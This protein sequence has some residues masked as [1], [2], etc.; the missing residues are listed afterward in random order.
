MM[1][2]KAVWLRRSGAACA[3][4]AA[5]W[6]LAQGPMPDAAA[7]PDAVAGNH[8]PV[9]VANAAGGVVRV[10]AGER[11]TLVIEALDP[12]LVEGGAFE[13]VWLGAAPDG[14]AP[15]WIAAAEWAS[16]PSAQPRLELT[17]APSFDAVPGQYAI[18]AGATD[19]RGLTALAVFSVMVQ[20]P[21]CGGLE[22][23]EEGACRRC[24]SH[25]VPNA[26]RTGCEPC[27]S[28]TER[29][30]GA[31]SCAT[32]PPGLV[33]EPGRACDCGPARIPVG[34]A[35]EDCPPHMEAAGGACVP[36]PPDTERPAGTEACTDCEPGSTSVGG[37]ACAA[38][39]GA[40]LAPLGRASAK[41][42]PAEADTVAPEIVSADYVGSRVTLTLSE[43]VWAA[44]APATGDF[45]LTVTDGG[46][47][48]T[49]TVTAVEVAA[50]QAE[51]SAEVMLTLS[52]ALGGSASVS[53]AYT[54]NADMAKRPRDAAGNPLGTQTVLA[55]ARRTL[56]VDFGPLDPLAVGE[57][58]GR[59]RATLTLENPPD[60]GKYTGCGL[61]LAA[62]SE[63]DGEDVAFLA[64]DRQLKPGNRW[65]TGRVRLFRV[66]DDGLAEGEE[67][68]VVEGHCGG[69]DAGMV[70][71][72]AELRREPAAL[73]L[74]DDESRT[75]TLSVDPD[76]I[77]EAAEP[78][79]VKVTAT[80]D[81]EATDELLLPL[82]LAGTATASDYRVTGTQ[83]I[84]IEAGES[85]GT[86]VLTV[87]PS[88]DDDAADDTIVLD[89]A[90]SG[91][92]VAGATVTITE[93][94]G[95]VATLAGRR[96]KTLRE[97]V[98]AVK[99]R[100]AIR[101]KPARGAYTGCRLRL[102]SGS[103]A[104]TPADV[105][106][107]NRVKLN[108]QND[109]KDQASLLKVVDDAAT[110]GD[111]ALV[112]EG[113]CTSSKS[114]AEPR[115]T[116]LV[117]RPLR[118]TIR[119]NEAPGPVTLTVS[120]DRIG[121]TLGAQAVTVTATLDRA[122][123]GP[124]AVDLGLGA[125]S[126]M[127]AGTQRIEIA[128]GAESGATTLT[129]TPSDDGNAT[130]DRVAVTG[131]ASGRTVTSTS[132]TI[133]EPTIVGGVD[134]SGLGVDVSVSPA[135]IAEGSSGPHTVSATLTGVQVP[136]VDVALAL[137][138]R[139]TATQGSSHDYTLSGAANW[140]DLTVR[141]NGA[142]LT[143]RAKVTVAALEDAVED[144][145]ET[146]T[147]SVSRV[148]WGTAVVSLNAPA[149]ATLTI[150][151]PSNAPPAPAGLEVEPASGDERHGFDV[152][153]Q[154][155]TA[156]PPV[157]GY[158]VRHRKVADPLPDW[159]DSA[160][161]TGLATTITGLSAGTRYEVRAYARSSAGDGA[162]SGSV[163]AY[164]ADGDCTV[165]APRVA[166]PSG[167][168]SST[169]L[170]VTWEAAACAPATTIAN[171]RVR[172][173]EDP[174]VEAVT[175]AWLEE[176]SNT[177]AATLAGL[178]A[179]TA[180]VVEVRAVAAGGDNGP[181]SP[182][183]KG[184]TALDSRLPPR[185]GAPVVAA[186]ATHG[187]RRLDAT[188]RRVT[189]VDGND[190][191][192][193]ISRY[194]YRTRPDGGTWTAPTDA[195]AGPLKTATLTR[196]IA[197]LSTGTWYAVQ[198][199]GV[200]RMMGKDYP[201]KWSE[202]GRGRTWGGPDRVERPAAY[203]TGAAV[204]VVWEAPDDG[205]SA[206]TG[207]DVAYRTKGSGWTTHPYAGC[208]MGTCA[209][210]AS[211]AAAA[212]EVRVRAENRLGMGQWSMPAK[213][214]AIKLLRVSFGQASAAVREGA[215][216]QVALN[217]DSAADREVA[218]P[219][220][221]NG[222]DGKFRLDGAANNRVTFALGESV[223]RFD[224]AALQDKDN[225]DSA[226]TLGLGQLPNGVLR[227]APSSLVVTIDDDEASNRQPM[228]AAATTTRTVAENTAAGGSVGAPV[229]ATDPDGDA[230][231]Y[232]LAGADAASFT[233]DANGQISVGTDTA[234]DFEGGTASYALT[235]Q[236]G[237]GK[238]GAGEPDTAVD[239][240]V[241]VT[242]NVS[243]VPEPPGQPNA[244]SLTPGTTSL[245]ASWT[246]PDNTGP[247]ITDYDVEYRKDGAAD[248]TDAS[249]AGTATTTTLSG[250]KAGTA[251]EVRVRAASDEGTGA[252]SDPSEANTL[253]QV[254]LTASAAVA[255]IGADNAAVAVTLTGTAHVDG[256]G[257]LSGEWLLRATGGTV[258]TLAKGI[259]LTSGTG[260]TRS[261][262]SAAPEAR[263]YG[264]RAS[265]ALGGRTSQA[266]EWIDIEW[267]PGV[268]LSASPATVREAKGA[269]TV[270]VTAALT[271]TALTASAKTVA[272]SV[273]S[274]T[275][276]AADDF[277]TVDGFP[278]TIP[279]NTRQ[280]KGTFTLT[281]VVDAAAE[282]VETVAVTATASD[283]RALTVTG[284]TVALDD[285]A[286]LTVTAPSNG[287]VIGT[288]GTGT[289]KATVID[290][291]S[292]GR[293]DC[294]EFLAAGTAVTLTATADADHGLAGWS[295]DCSG[296]EVCKL[297]VDGDKTVG[298]TIKPTRTLTVAAP[299]NG[300]VTGKVGTATVIDC[301]SDCAET[302]TEGTVVAL[303]AAGASGYEFS[304]WGDACAAETT[305]ACAV[306]LNADRTVSVAFASTAIVGKCDESVVDGCAAGTL[307]NAAHSDTDTDHHW[308]CDG[309]NGGAN[310]R[311]CTRAKRDC[312]AGGR[313]WTVGGLTCTGSVEAASSGDL[314]PARDAGDPT[315]GVASFKCDDGAWVEQAGS[316]CT[317]DLSCGASENTCLT[318]DVQAI[319]LS[320]TPKEDGM[321]AATEAKA[322]T[323]GTPDRNT[324]A[325]IAREDGAC[326]TARNQCAGGTS[327]VLPSTDEALRWQCLGIDAEKR[328]SCLGT[329]GL[330][331]WRCE[332]G[333]RSQS[334]SLPI[335]AIS[336]HL[337]SED[338]GEAS[339]SPVC[340]LCKDGYEKHGGDCV[341]ECGANEV[342]DSNGTCVCE[343][344][345][346]RVNGK[347]VE[348]HTLTVEVD[349]RGK[350]TVTTDDTLGG[351]FSCT[352]IC[353]EDVVRN[354]DVSLSVTPQSGYKCDLTEASFTM[355]SDKSVTANCSLDPP[356]PQCGTAEMTCNPG[357][358]TQASDSLIPP[359]NKWT[360]TNAG[361][362][363]NCEAPPP[364]CDKGTE[365]LA[366][367]DQELTCKC[368][369]GYA[370]HGGVCKKLFTLEVKP[371][372]EAGYVTVTAVVNNDGISCG[373]GA[374][375]TDCS[376]QIP[377]GESVSPSATPNKG[378]LFGGWSKSCTG[379]SSCT[380][381]MN[382][383]KTLAAAFNTTLKPQAGG[384]YT[385]V[386][387]GGTL[388]FGGFLT[389]YTA[390]VS[391]SA[392][393][394]VSPYT[395]RWEGQSSDSATAVYIFT[396]RKTYYKDVTAKDSAKP[397][398]S[399]EA[400]AEIRAGTSGGDSVQG[401]SGAQDAS[402]EAVPF[403]VPLGGELRIV[404][405]EDSA[406][407]AS[408]GD[409]A[410]VGVSVASPEIRLTG[411]GA[412]EASVIVQTESG[413]LRL[414]VVVK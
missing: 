302:V 235:V 128:Q 204:E 152:S 254:T 88:P 143:A 274:G 225:A 167:D 282:G 100:L 213:V 289:S 117:S 234:L 121:E 410:V 413:E 264:F 92:E 265:H 161:R 261:V 63:A 378:Y 119:D 50:A 354:Q 85:S 103:A 59:V 72:A 383:N 317:V 203:R 344:G 75:V 299:S 27:P 189:W 110:E 114:N 360:C 310:S 22:T 113:H 19:A 370:R 38:V 395:F 55:S 134:L 91:Y 335:H 315:R 157:T 394:G 236:V 162:E 352:Q 321:C 185:V 171:Y 202:P 206:I 211:I 16:G 95:V 179:D 260:V 172:Y 223:Q 24:P 120:P 205:G 102:A 248:W 156:T 359:V 397:Q 404:W 80:L 332:Y 170:K 339:D 396:I 313:S 155:V 78:T 270:T 239:A 409:T 131:T 146:V 314:K 182:A 197:G 218:V 160:L 138:V 73:A 148:T 320:R 47:P 214:Q 275:A 130:D 54:A 169:E 115:H 174:E 37:A 253:A 97:D 342:R 83:S 58:A 67:T 258:S 246:E 411:V 60:A 133:R 375:R 86:T 347:C 141:A 337:C 286:L 140:N 325:D 107:S 350:G 82:T 250:L 233:I 13:P 219:I 90:L 304:S 9:L 384:P 164:T 379:K 278:I 68:L 226:V 74:V 183:G 284:T 345:H 52:G 281:P 112:V 11:A 14:T 217:L 412:G 79:A 391:A 348:V 377:E 367:V 46:S 268:A 209:T 123:T 6:A 237:D 380:I 328:W 240:T 306:T 349:P 187:D 294:T 108:A 124:V 49:V 145:G 364:K 104:G 247:A 227:V 8:P 20:A 279:A 220:T 243:D 33:S 136:D 241:A 96:S 132:L 43:P 388:P 7:A 175:N 166:A 318:P 106:F 62:A 232:T 186:H 353:S 373:Y 267:R 194:Q 355:T 139:G 408:S 266:T 195:V 405:G 323:S 245:A 165:G 135:A 400:T 407:T 40:Q 316:T 216:L 48:V 280:A 142:H 385:A 118:L 293:A 341:P 94:V 238:D 35:C 87:T 374:A 215:S 356:P 343:A 28:G 402:Q 288:T 116:G 198:V 263:A 61:R 98:G 231:T 326:G 324:P 34:G 199:R 89:A 147:F 305:A 65:S 244:P 192:Q 362:T 3:L 159:T 173:R 21:R 151:E 309:A 221:T 228:F 5:V 44:T 207:Y 257:T 307:N 93:P 308:R 382:A 366:L 181:W 84:T 336:Y 4:L 122:A 381:T 386:F 191:E 10:R 290:C 368:K 291:G 297:T 177:L 15:E 276:T 31:A 29:P 70:P 76:A 1:T 168:R 269:R 208:R 414:P 229:A 312:L 149:S 319:G 292:G 101:P 311:R 365:D 2:R 127:V 329:D 71:V 176:T 271:G 272:V 99:V 399:K 334:C 242:V 125:G 17:L 376:M 387:S 188:W 406:V 153:W 277:K 372:P 41:S 45:A 57:D 283:G 327:R 201:G 392:K 255:S 398:G 32:C 401:A 300:K 158:V 251:Y 285:R 346:S 224:L 298:A 105:T 193:P 303:S 64:A 51:A 150:T 403:E 36:C 210:E 222:G 144:D 287:H 26:T 390:N 56:V 252:W 66:V 184:R 340:L 369:G 363:K 259:G 230:L 212:T 42:A 190:D 361:M 23:V 196:T 256:G 333:G 322:C 301:G 200:N 129:L 338:A 249:F 358:A 262:S 39:L 12:D 180:Y 18:Q 163:Y 330:S 77:P 109:W 111:E 53:L 357:M 351:D 126:Y 371:R 273:G 25:S 331:D 30:A 295:G 137:A 178:T 389:L 154:A 81:G 296:T 69:G 393:D